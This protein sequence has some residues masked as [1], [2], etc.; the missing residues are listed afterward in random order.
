MSVCVFNIAAIRE[1]GRSVSVVV[2][3]E[4]V[5]FARL[6]ITFARK[7]VRLFA[8]KLDRH[9]FAT[10]SKC[11]EQLWQGSIEVVGYDEFLLECS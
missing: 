4:N 10:Q 2:N 1:N 7:L 8:A 6:T 9:L 5:E 11:I 3:D